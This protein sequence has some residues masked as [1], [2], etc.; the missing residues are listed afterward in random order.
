MRPLSLWEAGQS[1]GEV[2]LHALAYGDSACAAEPG[3]YTLQAWAGL[4]TRGGWPATLDAALVDAADYVTDYLELVQQAD[5]S[6]VA[7]VRRD[8]VRVTRLIGSLAR[9]VS[10]EAGVATLSRDA[11]GSRGPLSRDTTGRY[12]DALERLM[13]IEPLPAWQTALRGSARLRQAPAWHFVDPSLAVAALRATPDQLVA[14]P[15]TLGMLFE[16]LAVRDLRVYAAA[17]RG[18][19]VRARDSAGREVDVVIEYPHGWIACEVKLGLGQADA[20]AGTL[21][22]FVDAVDV[23]TVGPCL[24]RLVIVGTGP[25]YRRADGTLVVPL[26]ALCP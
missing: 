25:G 22:R 7:G 23:Q 3:P 13:V 18:R 24:A 26:S 4:I 9:N 2:S 6:D 17:D 14:E 15:K 12:L 11:G 5:V 19:V 10:G 8:P 21:S 20:A 1:T 16:S